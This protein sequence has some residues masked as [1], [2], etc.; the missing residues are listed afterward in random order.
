MLANPAQQVL[1]LGG[2]RCPN[3]LEVAPRPASEP[4]I[5]VQ[6]TAVWIDVE[7]EERLLSQVEVRAV[8]GATRHVHEPIGGTKSFDELCV[9]HP[10]FIADLIGLAFGQRWTRPGTAMPVRPVTATRH[11]MIS[12]ARAAAAALKSR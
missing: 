11:R 9:C 4:Y 8:S 10:A 3:G 1:A 12:L 6:A 7:V 5:G 2:C